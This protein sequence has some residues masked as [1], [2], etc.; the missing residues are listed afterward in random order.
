M[1]I[2]KTTGINKSLA[3]LRDDSFL[4]QLAPI[5]TEAKIKNPAIVVTLVRLAATPQRQANK[6]IIGDL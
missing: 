1:T 3:K 2:N 4:N 6:A 5:Q